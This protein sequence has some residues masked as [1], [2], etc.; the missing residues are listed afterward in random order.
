MKSCWIDDGMSVIGIAR[1]RIELNIEIIPLP[2]C[3]IKGNKFGNEEN[4]S[5]ISNSPEL[6]GNSNKYS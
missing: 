3:I 5:T 6:R 1:S 4:S 2:V